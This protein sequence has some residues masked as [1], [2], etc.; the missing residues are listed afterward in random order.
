M[1]IIHELGHF[2]A[3]KS[4]GVKV[5]KFSFGFGPKICGIKRNDTEYVISLVLLGG[6]V[7]LAGDEAAL[8]EGKPHEFL[9]KSV[10]QRFNII[11]L[12]PLL[13][14]V[15]GFLLFWLV[16]FVGSPTATNKV[17]DVLKGYPAE[18]S[19]ILAGDRIIAIDGKTTRYWEDLTEIIHNKKEG[20]LALVI[21]RKTPTGIKT[22]KVNVVPK[23][24][25]AIDVFG[26]KR[27]ISLIG[28]AP[29]DEII[30]VRY[31]VLQSFFKAGERIY[32]LT[33]ITCKSLLFIIIGKMSVKESVTGPV[34][35]FMI[36][37]KA[38][39]LGIIYL[40]Q[41]MAVLSASI[42]IFNLLPVPVLDGGHILFLLVEKIRR[43][44]LSAKFQEVAAQIGLAI[45][46]TLMLFASYTD[47]LRFIVKK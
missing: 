34:G 19:K 16:F 23:R 10:G 7:K 22:L 24:R 39:K 26:K 41:M 13:N 20:D 14:Y 11:F 46:I 32:K 43:K 8:A 27:V 9:S 40:L 15:L 35:I 31:G 30:S 5:E 42:A 3:A 33:E 21:E 6:Y 47:L 29:S 36:T 28:I 44:P 45:L 38:A 2:I 1:I 25:E 4:A 12:G 17:G 37:S 18:D